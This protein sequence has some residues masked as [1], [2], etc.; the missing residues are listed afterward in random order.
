MARSDSIRSG[1]YYGWAEND[2]PGMA[3]NKTRQSVH[4]NVIWSPVPQADIGFEVI[5][6]SRETNAGATGEAMRFQIGVKYGF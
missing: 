5:Y 3:L 4:A 2:N 6:G 1:V